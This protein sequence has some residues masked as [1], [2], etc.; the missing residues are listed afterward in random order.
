M[1]NYN[2]D[3]RPQ[4]PDREHDFIVSGF[5]HGEHETIMFWFINEKKM[6]YRYNSWSSEDTSASVV[7]EDADGNLKFRHWYDGD[8]DNV[9]LGDYWDNDEESIIVQDDIIKARD[10][11][12][13]ENI[14]LE[15]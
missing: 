2:D 9:Y 1:I 10:N 11:Y 7:F 4:K 3:G 5:G 6:L 12:I 15:D 14:L 13:I 8:K